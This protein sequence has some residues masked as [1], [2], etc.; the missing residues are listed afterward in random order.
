M[1]G[2]TQT[3]AADAL[4]LAKYNTLILSATIAFTGALAPVA[5]ATGG[6]AGHY[7][8]D[9]D[10][11]W[12]TLPVMGFNVGAAL[13][14]FLAAF[15]MKR[16]G[17]RTG[18][19]TGAVIGMVGAISATMAI[20]NGS[21]IFL[22]VGLVLIG[23]GMAY[24]NQYR[25][26][27]ADGSP[28]AFKPQAIAWV[29]MGGIFAAVIG[30]QV[31]IQGRTFFDP[32]PFAGS[33]AGIIPVL[34]IGI[35]ILTFL[36][37]PNDN[38]VASTVAGEQARPLKEIITQ[39][40]FMVALFSGVVSFA[41][42]TFMMTGAPIAMMFCGFSPD[43]STLGIQ[44]HVLAMYGPSFFTG[45][46]ISRF[47]AERVTAFGL[48]IMIVGAAV[49]F[50]GIELWNFW[51][52]LILLGVGWNFGFIGATSMVTGCYRHSEKNKVQGFHD[53]VLFTLVAMA[54]LASGQ[55]LNIWGWHV[56]TG[57][58]WPVCGLAILLLYIQS[59]RERRMAAS[60]A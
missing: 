28:P 8:L 50:V 60:A 41:M 58:L 4:S 10:K 9:E 33:F 21:F 25:F 51:I 3:D 14:A 22:T 15:I 54:S 7:L 57:I 56:L 45:K 39:P 18:F 52:A 49:G 55:V 37:I 38:L 48:L 23:I 31:A 17:R 24:S 26:A 16:V 27:A 34:L 36:R 19:I 40:K 35:F 42:M 5:V 59:S 1:T 44:W 46:F 53:G 20:L 11:S 29:A 2:N 43:D 47:G 13:G 30:P 6:L 12:A 32:I